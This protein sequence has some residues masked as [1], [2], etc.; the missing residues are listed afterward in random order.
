[1]NG[2]KLL[3]FDCIAYFSSDLDAGKDDSEGALPDYRLDLVI[4]GKALVVFLKL[5]LQI[6]EGMLANFH[7]ND[8][9]N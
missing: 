5:L 1:M 7:L 9:N 4:F 3:N 6:L 8:K 2:D